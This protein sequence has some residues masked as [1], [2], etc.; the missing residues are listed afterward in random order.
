MDFVTPALQTPRLLLR[1]YRQDDLQDLS[2]Y[3]SDPAVV[4][5]EPYRP[6]ALAEV[7]ENLAWRISTGEM[8]AVQL[9]AS[10]KMIGNVYL[11]RREFDSLEL[12]FVFNR[13]YWG[14]GLAAEACR[15]LIRQAFSQGVHRIFAECDPRN[16][17][18]WRLL[19]ALGFRREGH[20]RQNVYF[21]TD[22]T[23]R[24][25]WKDTYLYAKLPT[26]P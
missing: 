2:E 3:L 7:R 15:A 6:M 10:G 22:E 24:P 8:V 25:L 19:E 16:E 23:G 20:L 5:F 1:R 17:N 4:A 14:Q 9:Q 26:E 13:A 11:G 12:G 18:S 21:H